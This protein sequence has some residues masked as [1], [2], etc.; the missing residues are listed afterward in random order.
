[1]NDIFKLSK[2]TKINIQDFKNTFDIALLMTH[3]K[4]GED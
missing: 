4:Y 2:K 3:G 1:V